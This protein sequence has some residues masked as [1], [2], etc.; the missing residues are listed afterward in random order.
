[1]REGVQEMSCFERHFSSGLRKFAMSGQIEEG[2]ASA[3][4]LA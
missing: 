1:V 2:R 4:W 3:S